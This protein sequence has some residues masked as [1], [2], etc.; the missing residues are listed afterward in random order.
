M[1]IESR[2]FKRFM[3]EE[4]GF[5]DFRETYPRSRIFTWPVWLFSCTGKGLFILTETEV[6]CKLKLMYNIM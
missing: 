1:L 4:P 3:A 6:H 5:P 2:E